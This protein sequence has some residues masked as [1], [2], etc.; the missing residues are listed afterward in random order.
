MAQCQCDEGYESDD[1]LSLFRTKVR[2]S[3]K[4]SLPDAQ[5]QVLRTPS[6]SNVVTGRRKPENCYWSVTAGNQVTFHKYEFDSRNRACP[7]I[8]VF[9]PAIYVFIRT[10]VTCRSA[11]PRSPPPLFRPG[12][13]EFSL[14]MITGFSANLL[15]EALLI[16]KS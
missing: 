8:C 15:R 6:R 10:N 3:V 14:S 11:C 13:S 4:V 9:S 5:S 7:V 16:P 2:I 12:I 1:Q